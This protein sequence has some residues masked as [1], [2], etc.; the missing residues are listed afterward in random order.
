ML[1]RI[2]LKSKKPMTILY[3]GEFY[4]S[5]NDEIIATILGSCVAVCLFDF[6]NGVGGMNH[7]MLPGK[8]SSMDIFKD[9]SARYGIRAIDELIR[10]MLKQ[11]AVKKNIK[12]KIFGGG[13]VMDFDIKH[14]AVNLENVR[15]AKALLEIEDIPIIARDVGE[16]Y[17]RKVIMHIKSGK[18]FLRKTNR[19]DIYLKI[20]RY[21]KDLSK[22]IFDNE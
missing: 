13:H 17:T 14:T 22:R 8:I 4:V 11:G 9:R 21:D 3:A 1:Q 20:E 18:V 2:D 16:N 15:L 5:S 19:K 10:E 12:A 6:E 7:F